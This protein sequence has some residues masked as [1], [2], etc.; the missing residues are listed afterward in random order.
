MICPFGACWGLSK[1]AQEDYQTD[2]ADGKSP[3]FNEKHE[4]GSKVDLDSVDFLELMLIKEKM[5]GRTS[6][7][8]KVRVP[9]F[10]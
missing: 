10:T 7:T 6:T 1:V 3:E 9:L 8:G 2:A 5:F 4:F